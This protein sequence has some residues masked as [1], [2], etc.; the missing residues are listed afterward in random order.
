MRPL[1]SGRSSLKPARSSRKA[2]Y[3]ARLGRSSA[4]G[5]HPVA[6]FA[7]AAA[8]VLLSRF[9]TRLQRS[10]GCALAAGRCPSGPASPLPWGRSAFPESP[11]RRSRASLGIKSKID[12]PGSCRSPN[13]AERPLAS[14]VDAFAASATDSYSWAPALAEADFED[15]QPGGIL[16]GGYLD[17][18]V[19]SAMSAARMKPVSGG[20][21]SMEARFSRANAFVDAFF[22]TNTGPSPVPG[23]ANLLGFLPF[24]SFPIVLLKEIFGP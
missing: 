15:F 7:N 14:S 16:G 12:L 10:F 3:L 13:S 9:G 2:T 22:E 17:L 24:L 6:P 21:P 19:N 1:R 20:R 5:I 18:L 4:Y 11:A 8:A 23:F